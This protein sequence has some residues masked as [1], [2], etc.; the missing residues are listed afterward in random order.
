MLGRLLLYVTVLALAVI[1]G[2]PFIWAVLTSFKT[3]REIFV[4]PPAFFPARFQ[5]QNY[6]DIWHQKAPFAIFFQNSIMV[7]MAT[8]AGQLVSASLVAY[9]F[10]RFRFPGRNLLFV[11]VL[12]TLMLPA[13]ITVIPTFILFK[14]LGWLDSFKPLVVPAY[15]GGGAFAIFLFR[16]FFMTIPKEFDEAAKIDG[17]ST[18]SIF[19]RILVPM[20]KPVFI[21]MAIFSFLGS[22]NDFFHP[23]IYLN[24]KEKFTL[25]IGLQY[26]RRSADA[27]GGATEHLLMA[28]AMM[29]TLPCLLVFIVL[30]RYFVRGVVMSGLKG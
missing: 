20:S 18:L 8:M 21:T 17:A 6:V 9:G 4:F 14:V 11:L 12:S 29:M 28:G 5:W 26:F 22:W 15:F 7:T 16:Q 25:Q 19:W 13:Q 23:L 27:G 30:Q 2:L 1:F 3:P 24:T 10:A